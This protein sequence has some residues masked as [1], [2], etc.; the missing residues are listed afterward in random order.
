MISSKMVARMAIVVLLTAV[1]TAFAE[2]KDKALKSEKGK[3]AEKIS[4][5]AEKSQSGAE[6]K[7]SNTAESEAV[8]SDLT[9]HD[10]DNPAEKSDKNTV[11]NIDG[12]S[13]DIAEKKEPKKVDWM[14]RSKRGSRG[15][16][17]CYVDKDGIPTA[18]FVIGV[19]PV[20]KT[21]IAVE[22]EE[23]AQY[24]AEAN[25]KEA[26][27]LWMQEFVKVENVREKK[28]IIVRNDG[29]E[30]SETETKVKRV[31]TQTASASWR[32]MSLWADSLKDGRYVAI[33]RWSVKEQEMAK[34]VEMLTQDGSPDSVLGKKER[35]VDWNVEEREFS[36][37]EDD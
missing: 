36:T 15:N 27:A 26:F 18:V 5:R 9:F 32:G 24:E 22:A 33:W 30:H 19:A 4:R 10:D 23:E 6:S 2:S 35:K 8:N 14:K 3:P 29:E 7:K 31:F 13:F 12:V 11:K 21:L 37:R 25:A 34:M 1:A 16:V 20:S 28:T 17:T